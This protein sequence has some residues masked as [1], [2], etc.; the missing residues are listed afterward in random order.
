MSGSPNISMP[1]ETAHAQNAD[2][3]YAGGYSSK[4]V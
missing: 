2:F 3:V 1:L 4:L